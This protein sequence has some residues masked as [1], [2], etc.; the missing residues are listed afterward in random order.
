MADDREAALVVGTLLILAFGVFI[1]VVQ[2]GS[3]P[4][5]VGGTPRDND[6]TR[7]PEEDRGR[8]TTNYS[9]GTAGI[10][11]Q[12]GLSLGNN[13]DLLTDTDSSRLPGA[14][15]KHGY[16]Y[17]CKPG[18]VIEAVMSG[19]GCYQP[20]IPRSERSWMYSPPSRAV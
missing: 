1:G 7:W 14:W 20:P 11:V 15:Q 19:P 16:R 8:G 4:S 2:L 5:A 12:L 3:M 13:P 6:S 9:G 18:E 10:G 17:P